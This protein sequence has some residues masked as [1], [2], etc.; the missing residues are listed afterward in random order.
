MSLVLDVQT[1]SVV[2]ASASVVAGAIYYMLET[3]HQRRERQTEAILKLSPWFS[4]DAKELQ[5]AISNVCAAEYTDYADYIEKYAD[6]PQYS[7]LKLLGNYFE[8]IGLLIYRN[9]VE[10]DIVFDFWGDLSLSLWE[11]NEELIVAMRKES[12]TPTM[13]EYW[14]F[15]AKEMKKRKLAKKK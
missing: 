7:S 15:L 9:L 12:G 3:R 5:E 4:L 1:F 13:F 8:G 2:I 14:E 6:T 11:G 10:T